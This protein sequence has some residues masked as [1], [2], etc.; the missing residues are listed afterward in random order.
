MTLQL[1]HS[2]FPYIWG[3]PDF[4]FLSVYT[5]AGW[6]GGGGSIFWKT[7]DI[8]LASYS[9][10]SLRETTTQASSFSFSS[11]T[12]SVSSS[13]LQAVNR[14]WAKCFLHSS[15]KQRWASTHVNRSNTR[16]RLKTLPS[17]GRSNRSSFFKKPK[18]LV[19]PSISMFKKVYCRF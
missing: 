19:A 18:I 2:E 16:R 1:L 6:W 10:I 7:P 8:G 11:P 12:H 15:Y 13:Q 17:I 3:K 4:L 14:C 9:L 5:L